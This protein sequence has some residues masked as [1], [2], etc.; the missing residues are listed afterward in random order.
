MECNIQGNK[1]SF[2][3]SLNNYSIETIYKCFYWYTSDFEVDIN[4]DN[5]KCHILLTLKAD[6]LCDFKPVISR[7][8]QDLIDFKLREIVN[9]QTQTIRELIVAK[10]FAN[11]EE[12]GVPQSNVSD[13]VGFNPTEI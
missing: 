13:P 1:C 6:S 11:F 3:L 9:Q 2:Y 8:K 12:F 7:I 4:P 10:A 5:L